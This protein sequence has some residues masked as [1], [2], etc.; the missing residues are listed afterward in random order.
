MSHEN[1]EWFRTAHEHFG[2]TSMRVLI[3]NL[4]GSAPTIDAQTR[5][6]KEM[7]GPVFSSARARRRSWCCA[8]QTL[9]NAGGP[10]FARPD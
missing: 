1:A 4:L 3:M 9:L 5:R 2:R 6:T 7:L 8:S 10:P